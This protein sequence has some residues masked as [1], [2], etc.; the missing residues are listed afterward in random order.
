LWRRPADAG[1]GDALE[2]VLGARAGTL[3]RFDR[4]QLA[5]VI[6][7]CRRAR[8]LSEAGR[9]L[10]AVSRTR[11]RTTN[12]ADRLAKYLATHGLDWEAVRAAGSETRDARP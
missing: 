12:D 3:D 7:A 5:E 2:E 4:V 6:R 1:D 10:F 8:S 9:E 11:K